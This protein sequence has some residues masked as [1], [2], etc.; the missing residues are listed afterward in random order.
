MAL[1]RLLLA[2]FLSTASVYADDMLNQ[3][4]IFNKGQYVCDGS[5]SNCVRAKQ[6]NNVGGITDNGDGSVQFLGGG[7]GSGNVGAGTTTHFGGYVGVTTIGPFQTVEVAGNVGMG[8]TTPT[9]LLHLHGIDPVTLNINS[10]SSAATTTNVDWLVVGGGGASGATVG[11]DASGGG[12]AGGY[13]DSATE[14]QLSITLGGS[15]SITVGTGGTAGAGNGGNGNSSIFSTVTSLGGGGGARGGAGTVSGASGG[16]GGGGV[17]TSSGGAGTVGQG[18]NGGAS[19][20]GGGGASSVG[21]SS[22]FDSSNKGGTGTSSSISG[23]SVCYAGGGNPGGGTG[24]T[25]C[26][27]GEGTHGGFNSNNSTAG[28]NGRGGGGGGRWDSASNGK[29]GGDGVVIIAYTSSGYVDGTGG[30]ITHSGG[31]TIHTFTTGGTFT[32]P[33]ISSTGKSQIKYSTNS[34]TQ[35]TQGLDSSDGLYKTSGSAFGTNDYFSITPSGNVGIGTTLQ[36][37]GLAV[38]NGNVGIGTW[39]VSSGQLIVKDITAGNVGIGTIRPGQ[40]LD[41]NGFIRSTSLTA[42]KCVHTDGT[43][44]LTSAAADCGSG[45]S[46]QW[47]TTTGVGLATYD[48]VGI[49]TTTPQG[50]A[51]LVVTNGNVGIGTWVTLGLLQINKPSAN[52]FIY[53]SN[54]NIGIGTTTPQGSLAVTGGNVGIGT[55]A[56]QNRID[57]VANDSGTTLTNNSAAMEAVV[58]AD[59]TNGNFV[60][61]SFGQ[62]NSSGARKYTSK[63]SGVQTI[64]TAGSESGDLAMLTVNAGTAGERFRITAAGNVGIGTVGPTALLEV[65]GGNIKPSGVVIK[66]VVTAA[67]ATSITPNSNNADITY[68]ANTQAAGTLTINADGGTPLNGQSWVLKVKCTNAQTLSWNAVFAG[69]TNP[70]PT[71]TTGSSKIDYFCFIYDTVN[72]KWHFSGTSG[73]F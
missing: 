24:N 65:V 54:G 49:G 45:G 33:T 9:S 53:D 28:T 46:S 25:S 7:G 6:I 41:V 52:P 8:T 55:W 48:A 32:A 29:N 61:I 67:D 70:L 19:Y 11:D 26:G 4:G 63:V 68:Q 59:T 10:N 69:G 35:Y 18:N 64:H 17:G 73:G 51:G 31:K 16:S 60:D 72:S 37:S 39:V 34:I 62:N 47:I 3:G 1:L 42:S 66:R 22:A 58:N 30:T 21:G 23:A 71:T 27:G 15:Y 56:P 44:T 57:V 12:G 38:M 2:L 43:G 50:G 40:A 13:R 36:A 5:G 20:G 14:G